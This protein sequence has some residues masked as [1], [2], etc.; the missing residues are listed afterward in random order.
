M[1]YNIQQLVMYHT[2]NYLHVPDQS[3]TISVHRV[4]TN[5][6]M[7]EIELTQSKW[8][9]DCCLILNKTLDLLVSDRVSTFHHL[10]HTHTHAHT[11]TDNTKVGNDRIASLPHNHLL[12]SLFRCSNLIF[13]LLWV[14]VFYPN[15]PFCNGISLQ[16]CHFASECYRG[17]LNVFTESW[18]SVC[19]LV[20][21]WEVAMSGCFLFLFFKGLT[22]RWLNIM[23]HQPIVS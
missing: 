19:S 2:R 16:L 5:D 17:D 9:W 4:F 23:E 3:I 8:M 21:F 7:V 1:G 13:P 18:T 6:I 20:G 11:R 10:S 22:C 14:R 12:L 15:T